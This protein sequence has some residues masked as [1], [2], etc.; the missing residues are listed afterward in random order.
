MSSASVPD[1]AIAA[2]CGTAIS[3]PCCMHSHCAIEL[4]LA[5]R[6]TG[7]NETRDPTDQGKHTGNKSKMNAGRTSIIVRRNQRVS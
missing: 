7:V 3:N 1:S 4:V 6:Q 2:F 5:Q